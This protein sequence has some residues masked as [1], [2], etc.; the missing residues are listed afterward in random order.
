MRACLPLL[1]L[2][3]FRALHAQDMIVTGFQQLTSNGG[4]VAWSPGPNNLIAFDRPNSDG[5]YDV[6]TMNPDGSNQ[7]CLTCNF[8]PG[9]HKGNPDWTPDGNYIVFQA[10]RTDIRYSPSA[11]MTSTPGVGIDNVLWVMDAAGQNFW[12]I[13]PQSALTPYSSGVLHPHFSHDGTK[14]IWAQLTDDPSLVPPDGKWEI[15][16]ASFTIVNAAPA[17]TVLQTLT[18]GQCQLFYETHGFSLDDSTIFFSGNPSCQSHF[19]TDIYSYNLNTGVFTD[20]TNTPNDWDEH[21]RP[22]PIQD[23]LIWVSSVGTATTS[24]ALLLLEYWTMNYDGTDKKKMTWFTD[25]RAMVC[26]S[27]TCTNPA[28]LP[29]NVTM[30]DNDWNH[31]GT[32]VV[33]YAINPGA[34]GTT[35][36]GSNGAIWLMTLASSSTTTSSASYLNYPQAPD[37]IATSFAAD[38]ADQTASA[39]SV[40]LPSN[41]GGTTVAVTDSTGTTRSAPLFYVAPG[42]V[43]WYMPTGTASGPATVSTTSGDSTVTTD[44]FDVENIAP[45]LYSVSGLAAGYVVTPTQSYVPIYTCT[46]V[47]TPSPIDV[48]S[49]NAVLVLYGTGVR[50]SQYP[51]I[52]NVS[53]QSLTASFAG[54]QPDFVGLDQINVPLPAS[55]AGSGLVNVSLSM[56]TTIANAIQPET[57]NVVQLNIK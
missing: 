29:S 56:Q 8:E 32:Q 24:E 18:P 46:T 7:I 36:L 11:N 12:P 15:Q 39:Q 6:W 25:A 30:G 9:Y 33:I 17:V 3:P 4:R 5:F 1:L 10:Q 34:G 31:D 2:L 44:I 19:G 51:V 20:L 55:L 49:G 38:L 16:F 26:S 21:S 40:P 23:K 50:D 54:A 42:Q 57:S 45:G 27:T 35:I 22:A 13:L 28:S 53:S 14:L 47:C 52:V 41:L 48:S 37:S 43:N